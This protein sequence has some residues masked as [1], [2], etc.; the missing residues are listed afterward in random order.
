VDNARTVVF[1]ELG[2]TV[3]RN[4]LTSERDVGSRRGYRSRPSR[5][6]SKGSG[7]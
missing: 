6:C 4:Q 1:E 5:L 2:E 7:F 3:R